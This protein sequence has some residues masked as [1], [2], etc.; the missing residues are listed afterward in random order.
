MKH[1]FSFLICAAMLS[2]VAMKIVP[3]KAIGINSSLCILS[4]VLFL[5]FWMRKK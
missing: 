4:V 3:M 5:G 2:F 1:Y